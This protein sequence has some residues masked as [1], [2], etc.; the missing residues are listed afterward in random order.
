MET[1]TLLANWHG[2]PVSGPTGLVE[3]V[4]CPQCKKENV[5]QTS[6]KLKIPQT[7]PPED[8]IQF[9]IFP[10]SCYILPK[11]LQMYKTSVPC[12]ADV[13]IWLKAHH[14]W[15]NGVSGD[16]FIHFIISVSFAVPFFFIH[17]GNFWY[18]DFWIL[19]FVVLIK[20]CDVRRDWINSSFNLPH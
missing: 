15:E 1:L 12:L 16:F 6:M 19:S 8:K 17:F 5:F 9:L 18:Y 3:T 20:P 11:C 10:V 2:R 13:D 7:L 4:S 14:D